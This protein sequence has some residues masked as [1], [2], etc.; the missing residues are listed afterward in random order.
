MKER[1]K[2]VGG[3][4]FLAPDCVVRNPEKYRQ[5]Q[6]YKYKNGQCST[7]TARRNKSNVPTQSQP[8]NKSY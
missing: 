3:T 7:A 5:P 4:N 6:K 8:N 2:D 1:A